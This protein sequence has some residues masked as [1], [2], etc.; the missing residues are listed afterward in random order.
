MNPNPRK[1]PQCQANDLVKLSSCCNDLLHQLDQCKPDDLACECCAL[2]LINQDC[3]HLCPGNPLTNFLTVLLLDCSQLSDVNACSLPFKKTDDY[4]SVDDV[5]EED[6]KF[7]A[8][9]KSRVSNKV[10][11]FKEHVQQEQFIKKK[12]KL[13]ID[14]E[15]PIS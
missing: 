8:S 3:Y 11:G 13:V 15:T 14:K 4:A 6:E 10:E 12:I 5:L 2:Q 9:L 1:I 7:D